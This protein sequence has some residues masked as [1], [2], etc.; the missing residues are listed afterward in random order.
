[1]DSEA[2]EMLKDA[3]SRRWAEENERARAAKDL[4]QAALPSLVTLLADRFGATAVV[5]I[6]SL[7][8]GE[9]REDSDIDLV[10]AGLDPTCFWRAGAALESTANR[11]VDL[12]PW[13]AASEELKHVVVAEGRLLYGAL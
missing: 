3:W 2:R 10:V 12:I 6:G 4:A 13:E 5:L 1:M 9:F 8:R 7:A 11:P